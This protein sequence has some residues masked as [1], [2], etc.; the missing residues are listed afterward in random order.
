MNQFAL[1]S[2]RFFALLC[3]V[4]VGFSVLGA[5]QSYTDAEI[6]ASLVDT[7]EVNVL[8]TLMVVISSAVFAIAALVLVFLTWRADAAHRQA[9]LAAFSFAL[10]A[11]GIAIFFHV[12]L[13]TRVTALTGQTFGG[14][15]GLL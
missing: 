8:F 3:L 12:T 15:Y 1:T 11:A 14:F 4:L 9:A 5:S 6:H 2:A 7:W 13:T 10:V